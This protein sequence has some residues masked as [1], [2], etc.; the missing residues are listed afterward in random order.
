LYLVASGQKCNVKEQKDQIQ[1]FRSSRRMLPKSVIKFKIDT[2]IEQY[3][4][5]I[6]RNKIEWVR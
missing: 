5:S 4:W 1:Q 3:L 2:D 6:I